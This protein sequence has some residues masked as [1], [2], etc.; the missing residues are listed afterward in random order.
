MDILWSLTEFDVKERENRMSQDKNQQQPTITA[1]QQEHRWGNYLDAIIVTALWIVCFL[2]LDLYFPC[3]CALGVCSICLHTRD[4]IWSGLIIY[5]DG[6]G[7]DG[8]QTLIAFHECQYI[9]C[10]NWHVS[11]VRYLWPVCRSWLAHARGCLKSQYNNRQKRRLRGIHTNGSYNDDDDS[12]GDILLFWAII[13]TG[14]FSLSCM[15][16]FAK[17]NARLPSSSPPAP[18]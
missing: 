12:D 6:G 18:K 10:S 1:Q 4:I 15:T 16:I 7:G 3:L 8:P 9:Q 11:F 14:I 5:G 17:G 2:I 13:S